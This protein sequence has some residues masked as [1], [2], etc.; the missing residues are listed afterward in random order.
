MTREQI[1]A[2]VKSRDR[3]WAER[4][5]DALAAHYAE[6]AVVESPTHGTLKNRAAIRSVFATWLDAFPDVIFTQTDLLVEGDRAAVFFKI[7]GTH[8]KPFAAIPA[9]G[10]QVQ[11]DGVLLMRFRDG[12]IVHEKRYYDSTALLVQIGVLK[13]KPV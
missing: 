10:R 3:A 4:S 11:I 1:E 6:D 12:A 13:A 2:L 9:S 8:M 5:A 7:T